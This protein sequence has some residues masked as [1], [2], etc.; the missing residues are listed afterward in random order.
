MASDH[1]ALA[2]YYDLVEQLQ[3]HYGQRLYIGR[4]LKQLAEG[5]PFRVVHSDVRRFEQPAATMA[6]LHS[7]NLRTWRTDAFA[8][9]AFDRD[10]LDAL[11]R[12]LAAIANGDERVPPVSMGLGELV[13]G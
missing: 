13:L 2:R 4:E 7:Q 1:P 12:S 9:R 6:E 5:A 8:Q 3:A 11:E 10:E